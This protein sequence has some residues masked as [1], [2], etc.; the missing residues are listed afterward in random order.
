MYQNKLFLILAIIAGL[1]IVPAAATITITPTDVTTSSIMWSWSP[2]TVQN[3]S[4]DGIFVCNFN[5]T[6]T[7]FVLSG[8]GPNEPHTITIITAGDSG[9]NTTTTLGNTNTEQST[10]LLTL[11]TTWWYLILILVLCVAGMMRKL[12]IFLIVAS[13]V[14]LY[15]LYVFIIENPTITGTDVLIQI[16]FLIYVAFFIIPLWLVWGVKGGVFK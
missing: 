1:L 5:P 14:S 10:D 2:T 3:L 15:A 16:P 6:A 9:S 13:A 12:G 8:L 11:L 7:D 4:I